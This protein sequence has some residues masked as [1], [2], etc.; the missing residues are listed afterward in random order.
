[1]TVLVLDV[2]VWSLLA[3]SA[4]L[5]LFL[6]VPWCQQS[7][8]RYKLW[9]IRDAIRDDIRSGLLPEHDAVSRVCDMVEGGIRFSKDLTIA[10]ILL[11]LMTVRDVP[12]IDLEAEWSGLSAAQKSRLRLHWAAFRAA[13]A[14]H[15]LSSSPLGWALALVL[16][17]ARVTRRWPRGGRPLDEGRVVESAEKAI[18]VQ[19]QRGGDSQLL[20]TLV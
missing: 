14:R 18:E 6:L 20:P 8:Y 17:V 10:R 11:M 19:R 12:N 15:L 9:A 5:G 2:I 3:T 7:L 13:T 16:A 4:W 1:M